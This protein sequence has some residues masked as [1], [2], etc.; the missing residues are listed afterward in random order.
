MP[1]GRLVQKDLAICRCRLC[2]CRPWRSPRGFSPSNEHDPR[3]S[4]EPCGRTSA[5][6]ARH[7]ETGAPRPG[8]LDVLQ[9]WPPPLYRNLYKI[10]EKSLEIVEWMTHHLFRPSTATAAF[11]ASTW[12]PFFNEPGGKQPSQEPQ[13]RANAPTIPAVPD[14]F[15]LLTRIIIFGRRVCL[16]DLTASRMQ[17]NPKVNLLLKSFNGQITA[18]I[19]THF[20]FNP[21]LS[22]H[23][24]LCLSCGY[25]YRS[26]WKTRP[27]ITVKTFHLIHH[28]TGQYCFKAA[29]NKKI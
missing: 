29:R 12:P 14:R 11:Q 25:V 23:V 19:S 26:G 4:S 22:N 6:F 5:R 24:F 16:M 1:H 8:R 15:Q 20:K 27:V 10:L 3:P 2:S 17:G 13:M 9:S 7:R 18:Q 28:D 21:D